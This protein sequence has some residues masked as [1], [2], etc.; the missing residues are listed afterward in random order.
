VVNKVYFN[1]GKDNNDDAYNLHI[2]F[3][4]YPFRL[5]YSKHCLSGYRFGFCHLEKVKGI[6]LKIYKIDFFLSWDGR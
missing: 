3:R 1:I 2:I 5:V 6:W 4:L